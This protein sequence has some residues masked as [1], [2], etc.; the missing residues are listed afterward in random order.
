MDTTPL[1]WYYT[2]II[3]TLRYEGPHILLWR[4]LRM[5]ISPLGVMGLI[6]FYKKDLTQPL[7]EIRAKVPLNIGQ[8]TES[9]IEQ[10]VTLVKKRYGPAKNMLGQYRNRGIRDN[11]L[12]RFRQGHRCF[13]GK[14]GTEIVH[15]NWIFFHWKESIAG[16][17][18]FIN[19]RDDEA[20]MDD[21]CTAEAWRGKGIHGDVH[22]QMLLF[23]QQAGYRKAY[24]I[25]TSDN[26]SSQKPLHRIGWKISGTMFYFIPRGAEKARIFRIKGTLAPFVDKQAPIL[27]IKTER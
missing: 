2:Q 23:L 16:T 21:A 20:L 5:C 11:I 8:A 1:R 12:E 3:E 18:R 9:D 15:Y 27:T 6:T 26:K 14:I 22:N 19:L 7:G 13:V 4:T 24:T 25:G 17:G 10:L